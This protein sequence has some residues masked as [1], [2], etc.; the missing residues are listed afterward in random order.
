MLYIPD[1][2]FNSTRKFVMTDN[3][4]YPLESIVN[5]FLDLHDQTDDTLTRLKV[6]K[7]TLDLWS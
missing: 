7:M 2:Y 5:I 1:S 3:I 4:L 6:L